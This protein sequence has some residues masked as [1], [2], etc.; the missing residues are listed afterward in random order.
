MYFSHF[1]ENN[2]CFVLGSYVGISYFSHL[3]LLITP[4]QT[5]KGNEVF[6][7]PGGFNKA[8]LFQSAG[9]RVFLNRHIFQTNSEAGSNKRFG[10]VGLA[11]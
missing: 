10:A 9:E 2:G 7:L 5:T 11:L 8:R 4:L 6:R 3:R 1:C